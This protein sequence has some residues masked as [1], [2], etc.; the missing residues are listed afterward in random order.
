[1][2][3]EPMRPAQIVTEEDDLVGLE[4]LDRHPKRD[5]P[6]ITAAHVAGELLDALHRNA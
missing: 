5:Q 4:D 1:M 3:A 2:V 6:G